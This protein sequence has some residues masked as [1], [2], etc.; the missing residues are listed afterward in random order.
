MTEEQGLWRGAEGKPRERDRR[1]MRGEKNNV[2]CL[3]CKVQIYLPVCHGRKGGLFN[4]ETTSGYVRGYLDKYEKKCTM[5]WRYESVLVM[6]WQGGLARKGAC[7][8]AWWPKFNPQDPDGGRREV[9][10]TVVLCPIH[11]CYTSTRGPTH[12]CKTPLKE[13]VI[14]KLILY[15]NWKI[16]NKKGNISTLEMEVDASGVQVHL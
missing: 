13:N 7:H 8:Q 16:N 9:T 10:A 3:F 14:T 15:T 2:F 1:I 4:G 6:G 12:K 11:K 5:V